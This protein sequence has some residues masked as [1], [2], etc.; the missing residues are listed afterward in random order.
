MIKSFGFHSMKNDEFM[1]G[2]KARLY[3]QVII[4]NII[5]AIIFQNITLWNVC[6]NL[7]KNDMNIPSSALYKN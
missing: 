3:K 2:R 4:K 6:D 1:H 7:T 5:R